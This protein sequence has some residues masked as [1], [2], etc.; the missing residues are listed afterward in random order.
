MDI[1]ILAL[2]ILLFFGARFIKDGYCTEPFA[3]AQTASINGFFVTM[4]FIRHFF[5]YVEVGEYDHLLAIIDGR[6]GQLIVVTFMLFSGYAVMYKIDED[7]GYLD[8]LPKKILS[9]WFR[10]AVCILLFL[11]VDCIVGDHYSVSEVALAFVGLF[12]IGNS[13]WYIVAIICLWLFTYIS[14]KTCESNKRALVVL[15]VLMLAYSAVFYIVK[16]STWFDTIIA[17]YLGMFLFLLKDTITEFITGGGLLRYWGLWAVSLLVTALGSFVGNFIVFEIRV[18]AFSSFVVLSCY[19]FRIKNKALLFLGS[20]VFEIYI[21]QR[22]PMICFQGAFSINLVYFI[23]CLIITICMA[24]LFK[25]GAGFL[26]DWLS[27]NVWPRL[28]RQRTNG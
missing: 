13:T 2:V 23:V 12:S 7:R 10:F 20:Y 5:Q 17:Y 15:A 6:L 25:K 8:K 22:L 11:V 19:K 21:L 18:V 14:F 4:V 16:T 28:V 26:D 1:L 24:V 27:R 9:L 3:I